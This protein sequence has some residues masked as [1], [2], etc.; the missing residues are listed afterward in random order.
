MSKGIVILSTILPLNIK[1]I[2]KFI[3]LKMEIFITKDLY[4]L[5]TFLVLIILSLSTSIDYHVN[6]SLDVL[7]HEG[8]SYTPV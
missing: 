2:I 8:I 5:F 4:S 7:C 1:I 3:A 6:Y